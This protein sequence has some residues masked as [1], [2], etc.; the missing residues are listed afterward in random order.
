MSHSLSC[1]RVKG[2]SRAFYIINKAKVHVH[3]F[4]YKSCLPVVLYIVIMSRKWSPNFTESELQTL[5]DEVE[6]HKSILFSKLS[7]VITNSAKKKV[8]DTICT[9]INAAKQTDHRRTVDEI[10]K[11]WTTYM[12]NTKKQVSYNRREARRTSS[13]RTINFTRQGCRNYRRDLYWRH[14]KVA[15]IHVVQ[16]GRVFVT[17]FSIFHWQ[18]A[19]KP[20]RVQIRS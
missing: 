9:K 6:R 20:V 16:L 15:Q 8:W 14:R 3:S 2:Q 11:K 18:H 7:N 5:L 1:I 13:R 10:R 17:M 12:S 4:Y 19:H